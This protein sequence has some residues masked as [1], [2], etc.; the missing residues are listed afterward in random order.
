MKDRILEALDRYI[1]QNLWAL[2]ERV[3]EA[4][5]KPPVVPFNDLLRV[6]VGG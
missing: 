2:A 1:N 6:P 5:E 4:V 3:P